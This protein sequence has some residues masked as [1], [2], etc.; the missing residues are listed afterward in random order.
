MSAREDLDVEAGEY[1]LGL[2]APEEADALERRLLDDP[3]FAAAV[4]RWRERLHDLDRAAEP[5]EPSPDLW[6][7]IETQLDDAPSR[8]PARHAAAPGFAARI[9]NSLTLW[10]GVGLAGA[11]ASV[12]LAVAL[13][14]ARMDAP[15]T[16]VVIAVLLSADSTPGAVVEVFADNSAHVAPIA[17]VQIP[18]G[19]ALQVWT[20]PDPQTGPVSI[21]LMQD[22]R[23]A[24]LQPVRL[25]APKP[26]QLYEITLEPATGSP[27]GRPTGP[28][29][30]KGYAEPPR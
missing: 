12:A 4:G 18:S 15:R 14:A 9:W 10:R 16:P 13:G 27:T 29:L 30:F 23:Q 22:N 28:I 24:R 5:V 6:R 11:T 20:L 3:A 21:G 7:R 17:D 26:R 25:P 8:A 19:R 2:F 1:A